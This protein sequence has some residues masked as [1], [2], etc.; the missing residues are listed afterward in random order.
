MSV[1]EVWRRGAGLFNYNSRPDSIL[2]YR[3]HSPNQ[4]VNNG[5]IFRALENITH[6]SSVKMSYSVRRRLDNDLSEVP[7]E[8]VIVVSA[9]QWEYLHSY[10]SQ[11]ST[12]TPHFIFPLT[13]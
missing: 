7:A 11:F 13:N 10:S 1:G 4:T 9:V 2:T 8:L 6:I 12:P 3:S 5:V